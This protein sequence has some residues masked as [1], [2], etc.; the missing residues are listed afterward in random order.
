MRAL[1]GPWSIEADQN[2]H[3]AC[4]CIVDAE[5]TIIA[6]TPECEMYG[7]AEQAQDEANAELL[8]AAPRL[9]ETL[10]ALRAEVDVMTKRCGWSG[11]GAR[12][13]ADQLIALLAG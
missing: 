6:R 12:V 1:P 3:G 2:S 5:H 10:I 9:L 13:A 11:N 8:A 7:A 4:L